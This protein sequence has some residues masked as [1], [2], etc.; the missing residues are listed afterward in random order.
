MANRKYI[1]ARK[2][3]EEG[4]RVPADTSR[5]WLLALPE[6]TDYAALGSE[7]LHIFRLGPVYDRTTG[8]MYAEITD[9]V[10]A[11]LARVFP[12]QRADGQTVPIDWAHGSEW[13]STPEAAGP[14]GEVLS[15]E[16]RPGEGMWATVAWT[17]R[18][19]RVVADGV[20]CLYVSPAYA[21]PCF[22]KGTGEK[23]GELYLRSIALTDRPRQDR[24]D[25]VRLSEDTSPASAGTKEPE[26][27][28]KKLAEP[29][30]AEAKEP[31]GTEMP[32][33]ESKE[34]PKDLPE[35]LA[36]IAALRE[37]LAAL[38]AKHDEML[39]AQP[40]PEMEAEKGL[41][42]TSLA[43]IKSLSE[44]LSLAE[45][46]LAQVTA[47]KKAEALNHQITLGETKGWWAPS[48]SPFM[49]TLAEKAPE[50][51]AEEVK[52]LSA[53]PEI[54]LSEIG[55]GSKVEP[56]DPVTALDEAVKALCEEKGW[57]PIRDYN[58]AYKALQK[59]G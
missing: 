24:L 50:L 55:H 45:K 40:Q 51:F 20:P 59:K 58:R 6:G 47:E 39:K 37:E 16:H 4:R 19:Q 42:E 35:A 10:L 36:V 41:A 26:M 12:L 54:D 7:P 31:E 18:G 22:S 43:E 49:R 3:Q 21:G 30:P 48:R 15:V 23:L 9:E 29:A 11:E 27:A 38:Q 44:R 17:A 8:E 28:Q 34:D 52:R 56:K 1:P 2:S 14:L 53:N 32:E 57:D 46:Q 5:A 25:P 13:A 33:V